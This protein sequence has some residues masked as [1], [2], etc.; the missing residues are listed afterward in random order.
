MNEQKTVFDIFKE[1]TKTDIDLGDLCCWRCKTLAAF[2]GSV[3]LRGGFICNICSN[4]RNDWSIYL[5]GHPLSTKL[6]E[7]AVR[8]QQI[9]ARTMHDGIDRTE[10][11]SALVV[12]ERQIRHELFETGRQWIATS[13]PATPSVDAA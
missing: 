12:E 8:H 4:C 6:D 10:E 5:Q 11:L 2:A 1:M 13:K 7:I 3:E 9:C